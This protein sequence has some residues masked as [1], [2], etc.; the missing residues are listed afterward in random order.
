M[1]TKTTKIIMKSVGATLAVCSTM[2]MVGGCTTGSSK[3]SKKMVKKAVS[4]LE[5]LADTVMEM[6]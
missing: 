5:D 4:K 6:M 3:S 1:K 2:A